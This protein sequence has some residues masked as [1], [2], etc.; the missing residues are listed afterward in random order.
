[1]RTQTKCLVCLSKIPVWGIEINV[2]LLNGSLFRKVQRCQ[3][4]WKH[5]RLL[6]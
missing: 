1:M 4:I 5:V 6:R 2:R 3:H